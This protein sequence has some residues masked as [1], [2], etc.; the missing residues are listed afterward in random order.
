MCSFRALSVRPDYTRFRQGPKA[1]FRVGEISRDHRF[2]QL[3]T[4]KE[5]RKFGKIFEMVQEQTG[6]SKKVF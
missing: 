6:R 3:L 2:I 5:N 4:L 1:E